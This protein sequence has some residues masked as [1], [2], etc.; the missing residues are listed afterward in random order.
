MNTPFPYSELQCPHHENNYTLS[1]S[2]TLVWMCFSN[3]YSI[4]LWEIQEKDFGGMG[5][6]LYL[7]QQKIKKKFRKQ[8][9]T[10]DVWFLYSYVAK[11]VQ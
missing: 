1:T 5:T 8:K 9:P 3:I 6:E 7:E 10:K 11:L 2:L 4:D